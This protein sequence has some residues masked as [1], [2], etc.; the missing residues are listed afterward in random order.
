MM[1][2][3]AVMAMLGV[4]GLALAGCSAPST[5]SPRSERAEGMLADRIVVEKAAH[6]MTLFAGERKLATYRVSLGRGGLAPKVRQG[7]RRTPEGDYRITGR[8]PRSAYH[9]SLRIGYP[10][11]AQSAQARAG[12][13]D[14]G[15]DIMIHGLPN[16]RG[17]M[18]ALYRGQD[19][20]DGC[21]AVTDAEMDEIWR[22]TRDGAAVRILP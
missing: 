10:T 3:R 9:L 12:G 1:R 18:A 13:V 19:W 11:P 20:T 16:G 4:V 8:N 15:G 7:D 17:G 5:A 2:R 14:P 6:R 22:L 21:I